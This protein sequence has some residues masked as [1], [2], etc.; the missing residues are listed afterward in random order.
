MNYKCLILMLFV[1]FLSMSMVSANELG[2]NITSVNDG[3]PMELVDTIDCVD[4]DNLDDS[5]VLQ[6]SLR[7]M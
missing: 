5:D 4:E 3:S 1:L 2:D 7:I 6:V